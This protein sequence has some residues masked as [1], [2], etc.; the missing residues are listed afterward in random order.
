MSSAGSSERRIMNQQKRTSVGHYASP[1]SF[2][3]ERTVGFR[4]REQRTAEQNNKKPGSR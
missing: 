3:A 1:F 4:V 2:C